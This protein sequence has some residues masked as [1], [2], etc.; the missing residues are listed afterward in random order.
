MT[1]YDDTTTSI[2]ATPVTAP[3]VEPPTDTPT[4]VVR[5][6][7]HVLGVAVM[8]VGAALAGMAIGHLATPAATIAPP[9]A[10]ANCVKAITL[11]SDLNGQ[12]TELRGLAADSVRAAGAQSAY[13]LNA[14]TDK[15]NALNTRMNQTQAELGFY[16]PQCKAG[17]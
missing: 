4:P 3:N 7:S 2:T 11:T 6:R 13:S 8:A 10:S 1:T 12:I 15:V 17:K 14:N 16:G 9:V 5:K